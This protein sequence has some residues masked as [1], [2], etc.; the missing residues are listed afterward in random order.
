[1]FKGIKL[2]R[3]GGVRIALDWSLILIFLFV[4]LSLGSGVFPFWHPDWSAATT[5][6]V[7]LGA[8]L[9]LFGSLM[10]HV[11]AHA[12]VARRFGVPV[13]STTVFLFGGM[14][15]LDDEPKSPPAE[16][17]I[18]GAGPA[19]SLIVGLIFLFLGT[20][21]MP[22]DDGFTDP[23]TMMQSISPLSTLLLWLG[24]VNIFIGIFNLIPAFPLDGGRILRALLWAGTGN[25]RKATRWAAGTGQVVGWAL[26]LLGAAMAFGLWLP[27]LGGGP[28]EGLWL[29]FIGWF[30]N[31]AAATSHRTVAIRDLL[32]D[33]TVGQLMRR[34]L[35]P[36]IPRSAP[37][38]ALV[39]SYMATGESL[40]LVGD[41]P[42][43]IT[44]VVGADDVKRVNRADWANTPVGQ[45]VTPLG[46][47]P[48]VS[49]DAEA[50]KALKDLGRGDVDA[51]V[52][53]GKGEVIGILRRDDIARWLEVQSFD[54]DLRTRQR[55]AARSLEGGAR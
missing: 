25:L 26:I 8:T 6:A 51:M 35:P 50:F 48:H 12:L 21:R 2:G 18:A 19:T 15:H 55:A 5:W 37:I 11:L 16:V 44:G 33:V 39:D 40:F 31:V 17:A 24:P 52:V 14:A 49:P 3:I 34:Q 36:M 32:E 54:D 22:P 9:L 7:A 29:L 27:M 1:M 30:L 20:M 13:R 38:T 23:V 47:L 28:I 53:V 42:T 10:M 45:L 4:T 41:A 43:E 46:V